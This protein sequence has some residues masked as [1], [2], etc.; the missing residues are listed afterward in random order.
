[1]SNNWNDRT[2]ALAG[3]FQAAALVHQLATTGRINN[4]DLETA[5]RSLFSQN[6]KGVTDVYG[7]VQSLLTGLERLSNTLK[8]NPSKEGNE[9]VRY[10]MG[11]VHLQKK[12]MQQPKMLSLIGTRLEQA[13]QQAD[14]FEP[15]HENVIASLADIY[16]STLSTFSFRIQVSGDYNYLQQARIGNQ[17]RV[18]LFSGIRSAIL[19]RQLGGSRL[20]VIIK[21]KAIIETTD[22]LIKQA[23]EQLLQP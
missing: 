6:P 5:V 19:W 18:L 15:T 8:R 2:I 17:I 20:Q 7:E 22:T 1:M 10:V 11:I 12:L 13:Q 21:R 3:I 23:K 16:T 9:I 4:K 14:V